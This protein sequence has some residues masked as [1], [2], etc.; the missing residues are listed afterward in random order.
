MSIINLCLPQSLFS[1]IMQ[2]PIEKPH[3]L[4]VKGT[5]GDA[6]FRVG[7]QK[8]VIPAPLDSNSICC[9]RQ[10]CST[11][12]LLFLCAYSYTHISADTVS[13]VY[14]VAPARH[15]YR[16]VAAL[17]HCPH[18]LKC[19]SATYSYKYHYNYIRSY[20]RGGTAPHNVC[21]WPW[22]HP[23]HPPPTSP[24]LPCPT[25]GP[26]PHLMMWLCPSMVAPYAAPRRFPEFPTT[27][28]RRQR[29]WSHH[30]YG[31]C[32]G[33]TCR[34]YPARTHRLDAT[35]GSPFQAFSLT[36]VLTQGI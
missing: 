2:N 18:W 22:L 12:L 8:Y 27:A 6:N 35:L 5:Q 14:H 29:C 30:V 1:A 33:I 4:F 15:V 7:L 10:F 20:Y 21:A 26:P 28:Q 25:S 23:S 32:P 19:P 9:S 13:S 11:A 17:A 34:G 24:P 36:F 3:W 31:E 16:D